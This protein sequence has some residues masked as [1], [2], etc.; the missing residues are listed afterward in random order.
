M[1]SSGVPQTRQ[2]NAWQSP[3]TSG[4]GTA[5]AHVGQ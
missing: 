3:Q 5:F 2:I 4:S 1:R